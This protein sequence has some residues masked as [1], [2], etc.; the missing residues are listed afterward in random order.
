MEKLT[1]QNKFYTKLSLNKIKKY[2][3]E[4]FSVCKNGKYQAE[5]SGSVSP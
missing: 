3:S 2:Q 1:N 5:E 4:C